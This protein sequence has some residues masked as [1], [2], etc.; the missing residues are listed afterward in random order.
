MKNGKIPRGAF[1]LLNASMGQA[2][3]AR[4]ILPRIMA[5]GAWFMFPKELLAFL[6]EGEAI[7][8]AYLINHSYK[9]NEENPE[10]EFFC[11]IKTIQNHIFMKPEKQSRMLAGLQRKGMITIKR[12]GLPAKRYITI[13]FVAIWEAIYQ[14]RVNRPD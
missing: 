4:D 6:S 5:S 9:C 14:S 8:L 1:D 12:K 3:N 2:S 11:K 10:A 7:L 13:Y